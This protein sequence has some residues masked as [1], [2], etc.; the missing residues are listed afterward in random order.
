M[1]FTDFTELNDHDK[2]IKRDA[3]LYYFVSFHKVYSG[4][5]PVA[6]KKGFVK[7]A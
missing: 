4:A 6:L 1:T 2:I 3:I 7:D 5:C